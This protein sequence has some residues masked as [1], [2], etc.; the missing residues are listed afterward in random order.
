MGRLLTIH[1]MSLYQVVAGVAAQPLRA[2]SLARASG[3]YLR[4][5]LCGAAMQTVQCGLHSHV[6]MKQAE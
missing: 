1:G 2:N 3:M 5:M 4:G 6:M